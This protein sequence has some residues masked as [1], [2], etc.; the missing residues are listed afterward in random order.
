ML[1][2]IF[3]LILDSHNLGRLAP[4]QTVSFG[5]TNE[6][7][8][9]IDGSEQDIAANSSKQKKRSLKVGENNRIDREVLSLESVY[10]RKPDYG[11]PSQVKSEMVMTDVDG[12]QVPILIDEEIHDIDRMQKSGQKDR[13]CDVAVQLIL[14]RNERAVTAAY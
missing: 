8:L 6:I 13:L 1:K 9:V 14:V 2:P 3:R 7:F 10:T 4:E 11:T 12:S 5:S